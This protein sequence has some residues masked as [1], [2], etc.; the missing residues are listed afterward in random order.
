MSVRKLKP[1]TPGQRFRVVNGFDAITTDKPEKSLLAPLKK[2]GGR[3]SQGKMT[4][5]HRGGGHKRR[6]RVIDFKREKQGVTAE[7]KSIQYDPN[8]TAFI[9]LLEYK[10]GEKRYIIAQNGLQVGQHVIAGEK[11]APEIGNALFLS[12]IPLGTI[13]SCIELRPGQG[14]VM[15]RSAGTFAQLM[16]KD[17]KFVTIKMPSGET[18]LIL[19][20]CL[21]TIGAVSNSDHQLLVSGK[22]GRSRWLGRRPRT[23]PVV[24]NPVDH[25]MGGGEGK[26]S[27]GHPRS[28]NG[29]PAKGFRTRSKT[30]DSNRYIIERRKK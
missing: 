2:S 9:A 11:A 1:I 20:N 8:R 12:D 30:K 19:S 21:A 23:R 15:A 29:I 5:S 7:V 22:A 28:K 18:R 17:G 25:P 3:N 13:I 27:G 14:A 6:Y 4:V 16:A 24:M 26:S 10:D